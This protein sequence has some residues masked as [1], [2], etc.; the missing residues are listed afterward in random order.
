VGPAGVDVG[1]FLAGG[2]VAV[3]V[4]VISIVGDGSGV[5]VGSSTVGVG[6][7]GD[8]S[9]A[10]ERVGVAVARLPNMPAMKKHPPITITKATTATTAIVPTNTGVGKCLPLP[11]PASAT[12][13]G[14]AGGTLPR[15]SFHAATSSTAALESAG[16]GAVG[17]TGAGVGVAGAAGASG[18]TAGTT[19]TRSGVAGVVDAG[20]GAGVSDVAGAA[21]GAGGGTAGATGAD[22][23]GVGAADADGG[24][25][26]FHFCPSY[27]YHSPLS[28]PICHQF[29]CAS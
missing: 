1:F 7:T 14:C 17:A 13:S 26:L 9:R 24:I 4:G 2:L 6:R 20:G 8:G 12:L 23:G 22:G 28:T 5:S 15:A 11:L 29:P 25:A 21:G 19:G 10:S 18:G 16:G 3:L 27:M